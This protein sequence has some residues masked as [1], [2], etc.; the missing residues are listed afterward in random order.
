MLKLFD[1]EKEIKYD[2]NTYITKIFPLENFSAFGI[3]MEGIYFKTGEHAFQF[4]KF[5]NKKICEEIINCNSPYDARMLGR[6]Y[7]S[8]RIPNWN[9]IKYDYLEKVFKLKVEQNQLVKDV[10]LATKDYLI[11]EYCEDEDTEWGLDKNGNGENK[12]GKVWMKVRD[13]ITKKNGEK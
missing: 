12:L 1:K 6:K 13:E 7:K 9:E 8:E 10:L 2:I 3:E 11:C 5:K 4:L